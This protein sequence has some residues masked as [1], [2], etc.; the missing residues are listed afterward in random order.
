M[1]LLKTYHDKLNELLYKLH[2]NSEFEILEAENNPPISNKEKKKL[3]IKQ[4]IYSTFNGCS[5]KWINNKNDYSSGSLN[6]LSA[7]NSISNHWNDMLTNVIGETKKIENF[8]IF[9]FY[10][11]QNYVGFFIDDY[12][13]SGLYYV[14]ELDAYKLYLD[15]E[16]YFILAVETLGLIHWPSLIIKWNSDIKLTEANNI[17]KIIESKVPDF[18][19]TKFKQLYEQ[20]RIS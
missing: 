2:F 8:R 7:Q 10:S 19:L 18:N 17:E 13:S 6:I 3:G 4:P 16:S 15:M 1:N 11:N 9:D 20:L 5:F 14:R 12:E